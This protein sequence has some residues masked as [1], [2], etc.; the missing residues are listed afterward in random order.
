[1][2]FCGSNFEIFFYLCPKSEYECHL[3]TFCKKTANGTERAKLYKVDYIP[4]INLLFD[5]LFTS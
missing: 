5:K 2:A 3:T 1:M 4:K